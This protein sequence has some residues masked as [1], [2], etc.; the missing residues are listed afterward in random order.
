MATL[1]PFEESAAHTLGIEG[2]YSDHPS[3][4]GGATQWGITEAVARADGYTGA[5]ADLPKARALSIYRR[6]YWDRI[7][8]DWIAAVD[9]DT[10][11]ELFDTAVNMGVGV[12]VTFLQRVLN[13]LN[14]QGRDYPD[15][16][17]DGS[18]GPATAAALRALIA[19]RGIVG[20]NAVLIYLNAL[21][22]ARYIEL[23]ELRAAN[24]DFV[25]GWAQRVAFTFPPT[26][27]KA[28]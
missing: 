6:L 3:D 16:K 24:E 11:A 8:L 5:M 22:G 15:L 18:A 9:R 28:A 1:L 13:A 14:R 19:R 12:A 21:Q 10:A 17:V 26:I 2:G 27:R 25:L 7:G 20:R 4:R 23:A